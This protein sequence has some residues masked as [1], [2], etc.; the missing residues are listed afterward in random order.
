MEPRNVISF[1]PGRTAVFF[2]ALA[3]LFILGYSI[4][5]AL[6]LLAGPSL[7]V[8][9]TPQNRITAISGMTKR[10]AFLEMNGAPVSIQEDGSFLIERAFPPGYTAITVRARDRFG[11]RITKN[12]SLVTTAQ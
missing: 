6:P 11:K 2:G 10:V 1:T 7:S 8:I 9:A 12:I 5:A 4:Y 3:L